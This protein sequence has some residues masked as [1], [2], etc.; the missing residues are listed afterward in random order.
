M[1]TINKIL[2]NFQFSLKRISL[3][4]ERRNDNQA[5]IDR[6]R[7]AVDFIEL[8]GR[9]SE[10]EIIFLDEVGFNVSMRSSR[11]RSIIDRNAN[12]AFSNI[13]SRIF[14]FVVE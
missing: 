6:Y 2:T 4:P 7:Y 1:S 11:G 9:F 5:I 10:D 13:R 14:Q 12:L 3:I 8:Q